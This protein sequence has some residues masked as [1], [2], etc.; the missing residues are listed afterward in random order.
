VDA[1][2]SLR[3]LDAVLVDLHT[4]IDTEGRSTSSSAA[5]SATTSRRCSAAHAS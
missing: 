4:L 5:H 3:H 1:R 2:D